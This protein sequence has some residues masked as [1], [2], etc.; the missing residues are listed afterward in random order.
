MF[1]KK[2]LCM[3]FIKKNNTSDICCHE[4]ILILTNIIVLFFLISFAGLGPRVYADQSSTSVKI[5]EIVCGNNVAEFWEECD[6]TDLRGK[7]CLDFGYS[8]GNLSCTSVCT[9]DTFLCKSVVPS[10]GGG[11]GGHY[12]LETRVV[13]YGYAYPNAKVFLLNDNIILNSVFA[14][15][16]GKFLFNLK[17]NSGGS[18]KFEF[19]ANDVYGNKSRLIAVYTDVSSQKTTIIKNVIIPPSVYSNKSIYK[20]NSSITFF[21]QTVPNS[22]VNIYI[23][24]N[25]IDY[26]NADSYGRWKKNIKYKKDNK[27]KLYVNGI[28]NNINSDFSL[29]IY[30]YVGE[31]N[32]F[33]KEIK[34]MRYLADINEDG[35]I[36]I[37]D[38]SILI[39]W[40][41]KKTPLISKSKYK[42]DLNSDGIIN[43]S[44]F[45]IL[46]F[47][48]TG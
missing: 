26:V 10:S 33:S 3:S 27:I 24:N 14:D 17:L 28:F 44:D 35:K 32:K 36:D 11:G 45:S 48:W 37:T 23:N 19:I 15:D 6:G 41:D 4:S 20:R 25:Y 18:Y 1:L 40:Y 47:Y 9:Y 38:F 8:G 7:S 39:Y 42:V 16:S 29:P 30:V 2:N 22:I 43:F 13:I 46:A 31:N 12:M 34:N 5:I 21:G